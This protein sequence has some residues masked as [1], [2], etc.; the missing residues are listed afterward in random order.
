[1][2]TWSHDKQL[3]MLQLIKL[4]YEMTNIHLKG[5]DLEQTMKGRGIGNLA[6]GSLFFGDHLKNLKAME[7]HDGHF[8]YTNRPRKLSTLLR[9]PDGPDPAVRRSLANKNKKGCRIGID[10][11][12]LLPVD[13]RQGLL[14]AYAR[15]AFF[16]DCSSSRGSPVASAIL[17]RSSPIRNRFRAVSVAR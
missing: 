17:V 16:K 2:T 6:D 15:P 5:E 8:H 11:A 12:T 9:Y 4:S 3:E 13:R 10:P 14:C 7:E 1:M